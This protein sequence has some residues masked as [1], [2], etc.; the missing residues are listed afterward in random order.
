VRSRNVSVLIVAFN[1][2]RFIGEALASVFAQTVQPSQILVVDDGSTDATTAIAEVDPRVTVLRREH[3]GISAAR[4]SGIAA[5]DG[6]HLAFLDADDV[7]LPTKLERQLPMLE[8]DAVQ[9]VFCRADEFW[10]SDLPIAGSGLRAPQIGVEGPLTSALLIRRTAA[11]LI[12]PFAADP[13]GDWIDWWARARA[14]GITEV[15]VPEVLLRRRIHGANNSF[16]QSTDARPVLLETV[17]EHLR[18]SRA[19]PR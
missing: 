3:E 18:G 6:E 8:D 15:F 5:L 7:W 11:D 12:G 9:A 14:A 16:L 2:E 1:A 17:R 19:D 13:V 4:N 10:D